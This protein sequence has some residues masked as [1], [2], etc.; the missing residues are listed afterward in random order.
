MVNTDQAFF[1]RMEIT[2]SGD[3]DFSSSS[4]SDGTENQISDTHKYEDEGSQVVVRSGGDVSTRDHVVVEDDSDHA[5]EDDY[6]FLSLSVSGM[7]D[8]PEW[9]YYKY[10][11][12]NHSR[13]LAYLYGTPPNDY[14]KNRHADADDDVIEIEVI[15]LNRNTYDTLRDAFTISVIN[16]ESE[17]STH[18]LIQSCHAFQPL[19]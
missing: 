13:H 12:T 3:F 10:V 17:R 9:I 7:P 19:F 6:E 2:S 15:A 11:Y 8:L 1:V 5:S 18:H 4:S 16:T 14:L